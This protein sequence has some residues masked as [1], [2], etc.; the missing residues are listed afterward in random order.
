ME[1]RINQKISGMMIVF[2][3]GPLLMFLVTLYSTDQQAND[4]LVINLAGRQRMLSQKMSKESMTL[5]HQSM[6]NDSDGLEKTQ[7]SLINTI[8]VFDI[9]LNALMNSGT[10][11]LSLDLSGAK[12]DLPAASKEARNQLQ[13]VSRLW[14][15]FK[16]SVERL[17]KDKREEDVQQ[18]LKTNLPLLNAMNTAVVILQEQAEQK[19]TQLL[20][21]QIVCLGFGLII[22]FFII[23]WAGKK[24]VKPIQQSSS[25]ASDLSLGDLTNEI[26]LNQ[27][28]EIGELSIALNDMNTSLNSMI[29][30]IIKGVDTLTGSSADLSSVANQ[31]LSSSET[32]VEKSNTVA[33]A[34]EEMSSNMSSIAA[35][36]EQA[37]TNVKTVASSSVEMSDGLGKVTDNTDEAKAIAAEAVSK[38]ERASNQINML[39]ETSE[40]IGMVTETI[41]SISDKTSLLALNATIESARA[42]EAGKGFAVVANEIKELANQTADATG[43][44]AKKL[45]NIQ[46]ATASTVSEIGDV[47][48][49]I[50]RVDKIIIAIAESIEHQVYA[51][52]EIAENV[53]QASI[54][55]EEINTN[56]N[57]ATQA[58]GEVSQEISS[59]NDGANEISHSST[60]VQQGASDLNELADSLK[61]MVSKFKV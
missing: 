49:V 4:G 35:A 38:T 41:R 27:K 13:I 28:D 60:M 5:I 52:N 31:M 58:V 2:F 47:T 54:G 39:G 9:T 44:I 34:T 61:K 36:M 3:I 46:Q 18:I 45:I 10:V 19:V 22:L 26:H 43:D 23:Y 29:K 7:K 55:L 1:L 40:E 16:V 48:E 42:G 51:T 20:I 32:T 11:P 50:D 17:I 30:N 56:I 15:P 12:A 53:G 25:F 8:A 59:V 57:Q 21:G 37:S 33:S 14:V 24:I 6:M